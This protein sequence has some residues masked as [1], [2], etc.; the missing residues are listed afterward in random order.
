MEDT[1]Q[2]LEEGGWLPAVA[3]ALWERGGP[4]TYSERTR[5]RQSSPGS[6]E[7]PQQSMPLHWLGLLRQVRSW[8][9]H[10]TPGSI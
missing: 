2:K 7:K 10:P 8:I 9:P 3:C 1:E 4:D 6:G 5:G